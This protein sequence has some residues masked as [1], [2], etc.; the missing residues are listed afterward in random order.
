[1]STMYYHSFCST[2][3]NDNVTVRRIFEDQTKMHRLTDVF[4]CNLL[5]ILSKYVVECTKKHAHCTHMH[6]PYNI[7]SH[8]IVD[9]KVAG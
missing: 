1:M 3:D 7:V 8:C 2:C 4:V 6:I 5:L 9:E